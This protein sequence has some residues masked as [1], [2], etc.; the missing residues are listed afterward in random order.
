[1]TIHSTD[2]VGIEH[3]TEVS[4]GLAECWCTNP[5]CWDGKR[6]VCSLCCHRLDP[7]C[8]DERYECDVAKGLSL[9]IFGKGVMAMTL[10]EERF[11]ARRRSKLR[12]RRARRILKERRRHSRMLAGGARHRRQVSWF[13]DDGLRCYDCATVP[14]HP[15]EHP[16]EEELAYHAKLLKTVKE[17]EEA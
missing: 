16:D 15:W 12:S 1:M 5:C 13:G 4:R 7:D 2:I 17:I 11:V 6:C 10:E 14:W 3:L 8:P 9:R